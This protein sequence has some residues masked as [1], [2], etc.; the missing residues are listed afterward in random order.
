MRVASSATGESKNGEKPVKWLRVTINHYYKQF[1]WLVVLEAFFVFTPTLVINRFIH[2]FPSM[3][4]SN[5]ITKPIWKIEGSFKRTKEN[6]CV[7]GYDWK[8]FLPAVIHP[9]ADFSTTTNG[10]WIVASPYLTSGQMNPLKR[11]PDGWSLLLGL[12]WEVDR[13]QR[14][15]HAMSVRQIWK[16]LW[17]G[18]ITK[19]PNFIP[20]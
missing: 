7:I 4:L 17:L 12:L 19:G 3:S 2:P 13:I 9:S 10:Q 8:E 18:F 5:E 14:V 16:H 11:S 15:P 6:S 1:D 20:H